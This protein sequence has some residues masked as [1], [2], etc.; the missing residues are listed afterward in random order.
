MSPH[1]HSFT[2]DLLLDGQVRLRQPSKGF[3]V[4]MDTV[5]LAAAVELAPGARGFEPG[6]GVGGALLCAAVLS[7]GAQFMGLERAPEIA[8]LA[9]E[10]VALNAL[11][12]RVDVRCGDVFER[13][14]LSTFDAIFFNPPFDEAG[15]PAPRADR[16]H[17]Y[18]TERPLAD[19]VGVLADRLRG[20]GALT[21]IHRAHRLPEIV[22]ALDGRLG[23]VEV[24]PLRPY[25]DAP[26]K[27]VLVRAR[28]GSRAPFTLLRGLDLHI[29]GGPKHTDMVDAILRGQ[30]RIRWT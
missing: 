2:E 30:D 3:R 12:D 11:A 26:A 24:L 20:G 19:W 21:L 6:C 4:G 15:A 23:G 18:L 17:A 27:R 22:T 29:R 1:D 13:S 7:P 16:A 14:Q 5:L 9:G 28:K 10:N 25:E 8:A